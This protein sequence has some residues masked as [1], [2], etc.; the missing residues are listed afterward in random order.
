[1]VSLPLGRHASKGRTRTL[2]KEISLITS[3]LDARLAEE[4]RMVVTRR[5]SRL[6]QR[7][8]AIDAPRKFLLTTYLVDSQ[9]SLLLSS[10]TVRMLRRRGG[11]GASGACRYEVERRRSLRA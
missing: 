3:P 1:M 8:A 6:L 4:G 11:D 2:R 10:R 5:R 7:R 9:S